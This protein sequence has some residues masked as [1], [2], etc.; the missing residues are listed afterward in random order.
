MS[1][2]PLT[3]IRELTDAW[4]RKDRAGMARCLTQDV[5]E[6]GPAFASPLLGR[7]GLLNKYR[8][9][10]S[11]PLVILSYRI[12]RPK[13]VRLS[14]RLVMVHFSY[15]MKT[16]IKRRIEESRGKESMLLQR[17]RRRW[18]VKFIHWHRD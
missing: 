11:G 13:T 1:E 5:T 3:A 17:N 2:R 16:R 15:R 7:Q 12:L 14:D 9:Y 8:E 18:F 4:I 6:I 10:F